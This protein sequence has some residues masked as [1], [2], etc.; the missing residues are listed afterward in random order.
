MSKPKVILGFSGGLDTSFC[1]KYLTLD[2]GMDVHSV[3]VDTGGFSAEERKRIEDHAYSLGVKEHTTV[4]AE[5]TYYEKILKNLIYGNVL[6]NQ[7]YPLCVSAE[8]LI[9]ALEIVRVAKEQNVKSVAHG[10]TGAGNDQVRFDLIFN[11]L[12]PDAEIL[13]PIRD[14][15]LSREEEIEYLKKHGVQMDFKKAAYSINKGL[16]GTSVGGRETL[17]SDGVLPEDAWPTPLNKTGTETITLGFTRGEFTRL[18]GKEFPHPT[19]AIQA[20]TALAAPYGIGRDVHVGDTIIGIKGRVGFEAAAP[21]I[22]LK[23]H[24]LLEKHTLTKWQQNLKEQ[25]A[26][27]YG[28]TLH[29]G[30][31]LDPVM[32]D[33]EAFFAHTQDRVTGTVK[34]ELAPHR[35][36]CLGIESEFDMMR[37]KLGQYGEMNSGWSG[38]DVRGFSKIL[39]NPLKIY[40]TTGQGV[41]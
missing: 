5:K 16:W 27:F 38:Q 22:L 17:T 15:R 39:A 37:S 9:Q 40:H 8:R 19:E 25:L 36:T 21:L 23:A 6:K 33:I 2:R 28:N 18:N 14:L 24:H 26:Q 13:T 1:V 29:E 12:I 7:T 41:K 35:F 20:L 34:V 4:L 3:L 11:I 10:S 32:R 31:I 30:Q